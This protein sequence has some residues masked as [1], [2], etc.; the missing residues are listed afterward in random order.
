MRVRSGGGRQLLLLVLVEAEQVRRVLLLQL[1]ELG[2]GVRLAATERAAR[3]VRLRARARARARVRTK[4]RVRVRVRIRVR[5][6]VRV[7][8]ASTRPRIDSGAAI[9]PC[10]R[11]AAMTPPCTPPRQERSA[12]YLPTQDNEG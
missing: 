6:R 9:L 1:G 2:L 3:L 4:V 8:I 10:S 5:V 12:L 11:A 7:S